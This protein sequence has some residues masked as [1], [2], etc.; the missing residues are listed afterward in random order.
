MSATLQQMLLSR[1]KELEQAVLSKVLTT[2]RIPPSLQSEFF[3]GREQKLYNAI[4][5]LLSQHGRLDIVVLKQEHDDAI[6]EALTKQGT[7]SEAS[8]D[9]LRKYWK[10]RELAKTA[11]S[12][13]GEVSE[14]D[15]ELESMQEALAR[16]S[17]TQSVKSYDH[18]EEIGKILQVIER[19]QKEKR[20]SAGYPTCLKAIDALISGIE[21]GKVYSIGALKKTGKSRFG[22]YLGCKLAEGGAGVY[23]NSLEMSAFQ[24]NTLALSYYTGLNS[25][26]F[27]RELTVV[28]HKL[29][30]E[31]M[32]RLS[33]L[34][35]SIYR[36]RSVQEL[37]TRV[38][39]ERNK[40]A[41]D[42]VIIDYIQRMDYL[43]LRKDRPREV[44]RIAID[45]ANMSRD[46]NV[47]VVEL[48]QL[49]GAAEN[50]PDGEMPNM[51]HFKESQGIPENADVIMTLHNFKRHEPCFTPAGS[52]IMQTINA[53]IEQRYD[54]SGSTVQFLGDMRNCRFSDV[55]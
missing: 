4:T 17:L 41:I 3:V 10:V 5:A 35:W 30:A 39:Y 31:H 33:D 1:N 11:L 16:V 14:V 49:S 2:G 23:W 55:N 43:P 50:L 6:A 12:I 45:L 44:E 53:K 24:L 13:S 27:G 19:A 28:E 8:V 52:Y 26:K 22:V 18:Q 54:V 36:D 51:S 29:V 40:K 20:S 25:R 46:L 47:A 42:V 9:A 48:A 21:P 7:A 32:S 15:E 38:Q 34:N 37:K